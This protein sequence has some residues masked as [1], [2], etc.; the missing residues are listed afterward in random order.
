MRS[1]RYFL[2]Q[3]DWYLYKKGRLGNTK[4]FC[5]EG[6]SCEQV[7]REQPHASQGERPR[8]KSTLVALWPWTF[9]SQNCE[10][11]NFCCL[12]HPTFGLM[13]QKSLYLVHSPFIN[14]EKPQG[15]LQ[16]F[17]CFFIYF[18]SL[19]T[20]YFWLH[21]TKFFRFCQFLF[22]MAQFSFSAKMIAHA[23]SSTD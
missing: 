3:P 15:S 18:I 13:S 8:R 7:A 20:R 16:W 23:N 14:S 11:I 10:E 17:S 4:R 12:I 21:H 1:S 6:R 5:T 9:S 19:I 22:L 2:I